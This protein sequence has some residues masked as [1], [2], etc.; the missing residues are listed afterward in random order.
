MQRFA[1]V[2]V[3]AICP[4]DKQKYY[5]AVASELLTAKVQFAA[6]AVGLSYM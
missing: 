2:F 3:V 6:Q 4:G 5:V 1:K